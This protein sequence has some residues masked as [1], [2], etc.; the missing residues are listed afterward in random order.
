MQSVHALSVVSYRA[1]TLLIYTCIVQDNHAGV[2]VLPL[3]T[4][5]DS[6]ALATTANC[7]VSRSTIDPTASTRFEH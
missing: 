4:L 3:G 5:N 7:A 6:A 2:A 1:A